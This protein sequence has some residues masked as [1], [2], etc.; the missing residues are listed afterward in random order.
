MIVRG[1]NILLVK[2]IMIG[3]VW[4]C[5]GQSNMEMPIAYKAIYFT[6]ILNYEKE[7]LE[8]NY[9][10]IRLFKVGRATSQSLCS[11]IAS[12]PGRNVHPLPPP[13][14]ALPPIFSAENFIKN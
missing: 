6:G 3:E 4:V 1:K 14:S 7:L 2:N 12:V 8:T 11:T 13:T 10:Q 5:S 9:P